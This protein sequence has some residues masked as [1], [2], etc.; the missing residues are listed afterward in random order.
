MVVLKIPPPPPPPIVLFFEKILSSL[1]FPGHQFAFHLAFQNPH[2]KK[3]VP[4]WQSY[5]NKA[6]V[7]SVL[8][9]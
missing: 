3:S 1:A 8:F 7:I 4:N 2:P 5:E 9:F 6:T